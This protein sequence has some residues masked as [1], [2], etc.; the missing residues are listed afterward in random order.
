MNQSRPN[1][2]APVLFLT[3]HVKP[4]DE[5][6]WLE[7][8]RVLKYFMAMAHLKLKFVTNDTFTVHDSCKGHTRVI[9]TLGKDAVSASSQKQKWNGNSSTKIKLIS[10]DDILPKMLWTWHLIKVQG[11]QIEKNI[12]FQDN[13][14]CTSL[15]KNGK[16]S[17]SKHTTYLCLVFLHHG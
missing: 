7:L 14:S 12:L 16:V 13:K 5:D 1:H 11:Y 2:Q 10:G 17:S 4:P 6:D 8:K 9:M 15:M 3:T